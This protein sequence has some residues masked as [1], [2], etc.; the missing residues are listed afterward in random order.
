MLLPLG[1]IGFAPPRSN[2]RNTGFALELCGIGA[3]QLQLA[4]LQ[5]VLKPDRACR[6]RK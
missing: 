1:K 2:W 6:S 3:L 4:K 5:S